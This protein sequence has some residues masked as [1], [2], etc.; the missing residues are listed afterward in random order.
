M[1][2]SSRPAGTE[3]DDEEAYWSLDDDVELWY[4]VEK[5]G[6][7]FAKIAEEVFPHFDRVQIRKVR[8]GRATATIRFR[9][10]PSVGSR[11][12]T[13]SIIYNTPP[14]PTISLRPRP[15]SGS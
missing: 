7:Q 10:T 2:K 6:R 12:L 13:P 11:F 14:L 1:S 3:V 8:G 5:L 9:T 15:R 4:A